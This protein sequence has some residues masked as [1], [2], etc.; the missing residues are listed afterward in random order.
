MILAKSTHLKYILIFKCLTNVLL[1]N[2]NRYISNCYVLL[3]YL[4]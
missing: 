1:M 2:F 4:I 3:P